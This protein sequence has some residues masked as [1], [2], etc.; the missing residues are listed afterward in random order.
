MSDPM[1]FDE[2]LNAQMGNDNESKELFSNN[3]VKT[4]TRLSRDEVSI[5][6]KLY[7]LCEQYGLDEFKEMLDNFLEIRISMD[8]KSRNEFIKVAGNKFETR[9]NFLGGMFGRGRP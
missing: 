2:M 1:P 8:S 7:F 4:R 6:T 9:G 5:A 3:G